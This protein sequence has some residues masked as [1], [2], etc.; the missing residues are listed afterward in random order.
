MN[1]FLFDKTIFGPIKSRRLGTSLGVN[2]LPVNNKF[3]NYNCIYCECG[4]TKNKQKIKDQLPSK[5]K[6]I[7]DLQLFFKSSNNSEPINSITFAGNGEP[8]LHPEF[9]DIIKEVI[10]LR[11]KYVPK[12]LVS[13]L[14]N[15]TMLHKKSVVEA[16]GLVDRCMYKIDAGTQN[17][18]LTINNPIGKI[19]FKKTIDQISK[20]KSEIIIQSLFLKGKYNGEFIDNTKEDEIINWIEIIKKIKPKSIIIYTLDR[21]TPLKSLEKIPF[22]EMQKIKTKLKNHNIEAEIY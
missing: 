20:I 10:E 2:L 21:N 7:N 4:W 1:T 14:T 13:V 5:K 6:V 17:S 22:V 18:F 9:N 15:A 3:C 19:S 12:A 16:L 8:T 11:N